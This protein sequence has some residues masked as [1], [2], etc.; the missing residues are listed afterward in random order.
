MASR[1]NLKKVINYATS[2]LFSECVAVS[3]YSSKPEEKDVEALLTAIVR[4]RR[5]C[6]ER[7][8]HKEPGMKA[9]AYFDHLIISFNKQI[10]E[11]LDQINNLN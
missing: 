2:Q 1:K 8:S 7:V 9:K 3:L 11:I 4:M 10:E 5:N 6:I